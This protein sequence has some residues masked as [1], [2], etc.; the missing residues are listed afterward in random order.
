MDADELHYTM[1][2]KQGRT[3]PEPRVLERRPVSGMFCRCGEFFKESEFD[4]FDT[5]INRECPE[6]IE[7]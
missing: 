1:R 6:A 2:F 5:H 3:A 4:R 7:P